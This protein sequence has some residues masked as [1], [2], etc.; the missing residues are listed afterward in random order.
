MTH[1]FENSISK[2]EVL[3]CGLKNQVRGKGSAVWWRMTNI[4]D[5]MEC[6]HVYPLVLC[7]G[8]E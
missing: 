1:C 5:V 6:S 7:M 4:A 2:E 3:L 8:S